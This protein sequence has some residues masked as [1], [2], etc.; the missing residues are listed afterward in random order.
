MGDA[1][2]RTVAQLPK[3]APKSAVALGDGSLLVFGQT[4]YGRSLA[5]VTRGGK[6]TYP[7]VVRPRATQ[8]SAPLQTASGLFVSLIKSTADWNAHSFAPI[9]KQGVLGKAR[10]VEDLGIAWPP[11][12]IAP[13]MVH[14][15]ERAFVGPSGT[16][17]FLIDCYDQGAE[18]PYDETPR[19]L[20]ELTADLRFKR[21]VATTTQN[22]F[23]KVGTLPDGRLFV[24]HADGGVG[25]I[26]VP[27][28]LPV[29]QGTLGAVSG[30][31]TDQAS[32]RISC[33]QPYGSVCSGW[34]DL[35]RSDGSRFGWQP[36]SLPGRPG[37]R[38]ASIDLT[39]LRTGPAG[40]ASPS[41]AQSSLHPLPK[42]FER[43]SATPPGG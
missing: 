23:R 42:A 15:F 27:D 37:K 10:A 31:G 14:L 1:R 21:I 13:R 24:T 22:Q 32:V 7:R 34:V 20:I 19:L 12:C 5:R 38:Q 17:M 28:A 30:R 26:A 3:I 18:I 9:T 8:I 36:Y 16:V 33:D 43:G 39:V 6:V 35:H 2:G 41:Q 40:A 4:R 25:A 29:T 11:G